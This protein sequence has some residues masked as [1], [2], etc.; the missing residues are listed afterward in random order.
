MDRIFIAC[1]ACSNRG[2]NP[3]YVIRSACGTS[4]V[5]CTECGHIHTAKSGKPPRE[6][7]VRVIVSHDSESYTGSTALSECEILHKGDELIVDA[8][9]QHS[10]HGGDDDA[11]ELVQIASIETKGGGRVQTAHALDIKTIWA[12]NIEEVTVKITSQKGG[13]SSSMTTR[14]YGD[15]AYKVGDTINQNGKRL[16]ITKI[17]TR[18]GGHKSRA[19]TPVEAKNI[20]RLQA[21][22]DDR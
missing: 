3:H 21:R 20:K 6:S 5:R 2:E 17:H 18:D 12:R 19:G 14:A 10:V 7:A 16:V 9:T 8:P 13:K 1:P 11:A 4:L 22:E 15:E